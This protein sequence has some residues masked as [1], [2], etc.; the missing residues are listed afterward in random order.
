MTAIISGLHHITVISSNA[1]RNLSFYW[2][3]SEAAAAA[4]ASACRD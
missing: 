3:P 1:Q 2:P 4:R